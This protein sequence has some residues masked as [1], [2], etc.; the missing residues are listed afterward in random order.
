MNTEKLIGQKVRGFYYR[1]NKKRMYTHTKEM[2]VN[3]G[4]IGVIQ[5]ISGDG[6]AVFIRFKGFQWHLAYPLRLA[7]KHIIK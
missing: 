3:I 4:K 6:K 2:N 1:K 7:K 5:G